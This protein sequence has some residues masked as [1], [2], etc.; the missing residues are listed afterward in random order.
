M[1]ANVSMDSSLS[2]VRFFRNS[3]RLIIGYREPH[4]ED[5]IAGQNRL[6]DV[7]EYRRFYA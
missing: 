2:I 6:V 1:E 4:G 3:N 5:Y 7:A